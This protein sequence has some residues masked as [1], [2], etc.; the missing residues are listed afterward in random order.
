MI[1]H[2]RLIAS[3]LKIVAVANY[4]I[5]FFYPLPVVGRSL[6]EFELCGYH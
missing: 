3:T 5:Y 4:I 6:G 1:R 2:Y